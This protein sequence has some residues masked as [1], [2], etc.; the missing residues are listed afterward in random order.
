[1]KRSLLKLLTILTFIP[2]LL[3][4]CYTQLATQ[5]DYYSDYAS[6]EYYGEDD[7]VYQESDSTSYEDE[8]YTNEDEYSDEWYDDDEYYDEAMSQSFRSRIWGE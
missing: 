8:G 7:E 6:D 4:G 1:M 2:A 5:D 3:T